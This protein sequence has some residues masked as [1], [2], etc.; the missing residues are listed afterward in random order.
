MLSSYRTAA[1]CRAS[2]TPRILE[3]KDLLAASIECVQDEHVGQPPHSGL[4]MLAKAVVCPSC[5]STLATTPPTGTTVMNCPECG[6]RFSIT[7]SGT[8][9]SNHSLAA[10]PSA[11]PPDTVSAFVGSGGAASTRETLVAPAGPPRSGEFPFLAPPQQLDELG[12]LGPYRV[13]GLLG[14]GGM[15]AVFRAEDPALRRQIALKVMLPQFASHPTAKA[16]FLREARSQAAVEHN[17][18][19]A[20]HQVGEEGGIPFIAMPMLKGE[21]LADSLKTNPAVPV[22]EA[23]RIAREIAEGLA[24]AHGSGLVHRDIKP[25]N[26]WLEGRE[27]QVKVLDF[28]LARAEAEGDGAEAVTQQGAIIGTPAYMSPEQATGEP[29]DTR[30]D[31][32]SLGVVLY[33]MLTGQQ[34]FIGKNVPATLSAVTSY[35]P[36]RPAE[37][38]PSVPADLDGLT[39]RLLAKAVTDRPASAELVVQALRAVESG[40]NSAGS[41]PAPPPVTNPKATDP[42]PRKRSPWLLVGSLAAIAGFAVLAANM[43]KTRNA[44]GPKVEAKAPEGT[45][46]AVAQNRKEPPTNPDPKQEPAKAASDRALAEL[47]IRLGGGV[48]INDG[49]IRIKALADLPKEPFRLTGLVVV[50]EKVSEADWANFKGCKSLT[51]LDLPHTTISDAGLANFQGCKSVTYLDLTNTQV[52]DAGLACFQEFKSLTQI[53]LSQTTITGA[54]LVHFKNCS[55]LQALHLGSCTRLTDPGIEHFKGIKYLTVLD[56]SS[57]KVTDTGLASFKDCADM[58]E[59]NL[60]RTAVTQVGLAHFKD[61]KNLTILSLER[62]D[63]TDAGLAQFKGCA[64]LGYVFLKG[65]KVTKAG[66]AEFAKARPQCRTEWDGGVVEPR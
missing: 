48:R 27:R 11:T 55:N 41:E 65:T 33:Q 63:T 66:V 36:P 64:E 58:K 34:P 56:L 46:P 15:G 9:R 37:L 50:S 28:G 40:M 43:M 45:P 3:M 21:S 23:V 57:T 26:I 10:A 32:F 39:M 4:E 19:I 44:A 8:E 62:T 7:S 60:S 12:R 16:R 38:N 6:E 53:T 13:L 35:T 49:D 30:T 5:R 51:Y 52:T 2:D 1:G 54:G 17:H 29:V 14:T 61:C 42:T 59:L 22:A 18:I 20:I 25:A 47:A 31:L 24:A